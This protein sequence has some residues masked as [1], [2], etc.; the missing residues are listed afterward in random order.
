MVMGA[1]GKERLCAFFE[2][3]P[4]RGNGPVNEWGGGATSRLWMRRPRLGR[5]LP[6]PHHEAE[7]MTQA[8]RAS[9]RERPPFCLEKAKHATSG[10]ETRRLLHLSPLPKNPIRSLSALARSL[11]HSRGESLFE[12]TGGEVARVNYLDG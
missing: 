12:Q 7:K 11:P 1:G 10:W 6:C 3:K 5:S 2:R 4:G 9:E 8:E